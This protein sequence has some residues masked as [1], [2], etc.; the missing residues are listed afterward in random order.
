MSYPDDP[1]PFLSAPE[2]REWWRGWERN[3]RSPVVTSGSVQD[4][5]EVEVESEAVDEE[6][7]LPV[8]VR[9]EIRPQRMTRQE[10]VAWALSGGG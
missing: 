9:E 5:P 6:A 8:P 4:E 10:L 2:W 3:E 7:D 1:A